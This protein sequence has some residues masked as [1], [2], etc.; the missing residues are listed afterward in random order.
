MLIKNKGYNEMCDYIKHTSNW[1][2]FGT[3]TFAKNVNIDNAEKALNCF[4]NIVDR[5][6]LGNL[7]YRKNIKTKRLCFL[8]SGANNKNFHIHFVANT[9]NGVKI[10]D[11]IKILKYFWQTKIKNAGKEIKIEDTKNLIAVSKYVM[12]EFYKLGNDTL[13]LRS[14]NI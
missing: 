4:W 9:I 12:H 13:A 1:Q 6:L 10:E 7:S 8:Q 2:I 11:F 14:S 3:L 5:A